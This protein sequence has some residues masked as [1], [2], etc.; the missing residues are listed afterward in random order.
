MPQESV[1][2]QVLLIYSSLFD[3]QLTKMKQNSRGPGGI[4]N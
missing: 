3:M 4:R 2:L 1:H